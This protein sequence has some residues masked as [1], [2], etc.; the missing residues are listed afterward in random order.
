M[1]DECE[2][3]SVCCGADG[4]ILLFGMKRIA[5]VWEVHVMWGARER[6]VAVFDFTNSDF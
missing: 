6:S 2:K 4:E 5:R 1:R 3:F